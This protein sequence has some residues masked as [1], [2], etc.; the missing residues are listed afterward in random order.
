MKVKKLIGCCS[1]AIHLNGGMDDV[2]PSHRHRLVV[3]AGRH[4]LNIV[5]SI[6]CSDADTELFGGNVMAKTHRL[7]IGE[8]H[9]RSMMP[10]VERKSA[11]LKLLDENIVVTHK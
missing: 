1:L 5:G 6:V 10:L 4:I 7:K 8:L 9:M 11:T 3:A 2:K